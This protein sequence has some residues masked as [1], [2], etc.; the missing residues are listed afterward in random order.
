[1]RESA[2]VPLTVCHPQTQEAQDALAKQLAQLYAETV[3]QKIQALPWSPQQ[4]R[5]LLDAVLRAAKKQ[6]L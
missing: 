3:S 2:P 4:K 5:E 6:D 1:M